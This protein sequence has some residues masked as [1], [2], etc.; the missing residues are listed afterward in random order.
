MNLLRDHFEGTP[1]SYAEKEEKSP[2]LEEGTICAVHTQYG[3]V[4]QL[5]ADM[6]VEVGA[7]LWLAMRRPCIQAFTPWYAGITEIP[8]G[9]AKYD[10]L[11]AEKNH[12]NPEE[13]TWD[14]V[15]VHAYF[16]YKNHADFVDKNYPF[17]QQEALKK[18]LKTENRILKKQEK[19][20]KRL[21][22]LKDRHPKRFREQLN[23]LTY[24]TTSRTLTNNLTH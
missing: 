13:G 9:F 17:R 22:K 10:Y 15:P 3:M 20:E 6:P 4:A 11:W 14:N 21:L 8:T 16:F 19:R 2:H 7:V 1:L 23:N 18:A 24:K 12:Q 5:R